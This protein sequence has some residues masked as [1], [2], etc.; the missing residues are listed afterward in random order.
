[1]SAINPNYF[2]E[3]TH[4]RIYRL[5]LIQVKKHR[6]DNGFWHEYHL[7]SETVEE[8]CVQ[9]LQFDSLAAALQIGLGE[10]ARLKVGLF[11]GANVV[12]EISIGVK[13]S[14]REDQAPE[15]P[16]R[17]DD[18]DDSGPCDN[19]QE[20]QQYAQDGLVHRH[21]WLLWE[22]KDRRA[23]APD[24]WVQLT[25]VP[26]W[27]PYF[28][29]RRRPCFIL[30]NGVEVPVPLACIPRDETHAAVYAVD[31]LNETGYCILEPDSNRASLALGLGLL[32]STATNARLHY[33]ALYTTKR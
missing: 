14:L 20:I 15:Q 3:S 16:P 19:V 2:T 27:N 6:P 31:P 12:P 7:T 33:E 13:G 4:H 30:V 23:G 25:A 28:I 8:D 29:Y 9:R 5:A 1:M 10:A 32:H 17:Y 18:D 24:A 11:L 26:T 21:P 22:S